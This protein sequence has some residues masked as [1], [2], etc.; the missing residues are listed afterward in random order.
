MEKGFIN[1]VSQLLSS[2]PT[3]LTPNQ[4]YY[5]QAR[6]PRQINQRLVRPE[7]IKYT[8]LRHL[9]PEICCVLGGKLGMRW[10]ENYYRF[11]PG[12]YCLLPRMVYHYETY[13]Q[14]DQPYEVI[15]FGFTSMTRVWVARIRYQD[16]A[17]SR[18]YSVHFKIKPSYLDPFI[19]LDPAFA[20]DPALKA[21]IKPL[22]GYLLNKI[23]KGNYFSHLVEEP[24]LKWR[25]KSLLQAK[26]YID[27]HLTDK[28]TLKSISQQIR[29]TPTYLATLFRKE[30]GD[31]V[32]E[33]IIT[34]RMQKAVSLLE[35]TDLTIT[36]IAHQLQYNDIYYF[37]RL[38]KKH[39]GISPKEFRDTY[40]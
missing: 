16:Q 27:D 5:G 17:Y 25:T 30:F 12:D 18:T 13:A 29:I 39:F 36:E 21:G 19:H 8:N 11:L 14:R 33:Y 40:L 28:L 9:M 26:Q 2:D 34:N 6:H 15:W 31:S 24:S 37:S 4:L 23:K 1:T 20:A 22:F 32:F 38:Y 10:G 35:T 7:Y 3:T